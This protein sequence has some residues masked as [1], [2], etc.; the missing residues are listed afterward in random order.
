MLKARIIILNKIIST[1]QDV[2]IIFILRYSYKCYE[3]QLEILYFELSWSYPRCY[4]STMSSQPIITQSDIFIY[5]VSDDFLSFD[6]I[7]VVLIVIVFAFS[8]IV[9]W[10]E[11]WSSQNKGY[12]IVICYFSAKHPTFR[13]KNKNLIVRIMDN[14]FKWSNMST[15]GQL[16][17]WDI[18]KKI[19]L[20][21]LV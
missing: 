9:H 6:A 15:H 16:F 4:C 8:T 17:Q 1:R 2:W 13:I 21:V 14:L 20:S 10:F 3:C 5:N 18:A 19:Q 11:P 12:S 7:S